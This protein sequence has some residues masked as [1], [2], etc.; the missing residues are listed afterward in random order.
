L[1]VE[2]AVLGFAACL[3]A[4]GGASAQPQ[5]PP[6]GCPKMEDA[7]P[8]EHLN[9]AM[10]DPAYGAC[11]ISFAAQQKAFCDSQPKPSPSDSKAMAATRSCVQL[12]IVLQDLAVNFEPQ[13][14]YLQATADCANTGA[15]IPCDSK[16]RIEKVMRC[17]VAAL[18][19]GSMDGCLPPLPSMSDKH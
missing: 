19:G 14:A 17:N 8:T 1:F 18:V 5:S 11:L 16:A 15:S 2:I 12:A 3:I 10:S 4:S 9:R 6:S 13:S 7:S